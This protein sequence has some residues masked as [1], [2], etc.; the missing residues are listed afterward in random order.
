M[1][2]NKKRTRAEQLQIFISVVEHAIVAGLFDVNI[3]RKQSL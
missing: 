1:L 3:E 2:T